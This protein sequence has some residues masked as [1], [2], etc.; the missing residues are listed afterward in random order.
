M[1]SVKKIVKS[2]GNTLKNPLQNPIKTYTTVAGG[3]TAGGLAGAAVGDRIGSQMTQMPTAPTFEGLEGAQ[4]LQGNI[5]GRRI[6]EAEKFKSEL[7]DYIEG[8]YGSQKAG[9]DRQYD[10][11]KKNLISNLNARGVLRSGQSKLQQGQLSADRAAALNQAR[12]NVIKDAYAQAS[13]YETDP[14]FSLANVAE[15]KAT[16][17]G[18]LDR[19][20]DQRKAASQAL[21][22]SAMGSIGSGDGRGLANVNAGK[23]SSYGGTVS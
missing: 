22:G 2:V 23:D 19:L 5:I 4:T 11:A 10:Q 1:G 3:L 7:P 20:A 13:A 21:M 6:A 9:I 18:N 16:H 12:G 8:A 17:Q 14:L 15:T